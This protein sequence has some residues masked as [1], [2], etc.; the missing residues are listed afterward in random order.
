M[1]WS[2]CQVAI[3]GALGAV[4]RYLTGIAFTR[5]GLSEFPYATLFVN[6]SGSFLIGIAYIFLVDLQGE[7]GKYTPLIITGFLGGYTTFSA[8]SLEFWLMYQ[9]GRVV[10]SMFYA[11]S[12]ASLS[13]VAIFLGIAVAKQYA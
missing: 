6:V 7:M 11:L 8:F 3:G 10:E 9:Q 12:S 4:S 13:I 1:F 2:I 5:L